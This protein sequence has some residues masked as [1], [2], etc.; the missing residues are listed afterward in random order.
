MPTLS[1]NLSAFLAWSTMSIKSHQSSLS[2]SPSSRP[3]WSDFP[4][5]QLMEA[6]IRCN[7]TSS[8]STLNPCSTVFSG[9]LYGELQKLSMSHI[10]SFN[11]S[12]IATKDQVSPLYLNTDTIMRKEFDHKHRVQYDKNSSITD[13]CL[14]MIMLSANPGGVATHILYKISH[15]GNNSPRWNRD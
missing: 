4:I 7:Y 15:T 9:L 14:Q 13:W 3:Y 10:R 5:C 12:K 1:C 6:G 2:L 8:S 11:C